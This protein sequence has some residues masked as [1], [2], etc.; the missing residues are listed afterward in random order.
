VSV[1]SNYPEFSLDDV[2]TGEPKE[3]TS[4]WKLCAGV[5]VVTIVLIV[6]FVSLPEDMQSIVGLGVQIVY[7]SV[8]VFILL[9]VFYSASRKKSVIAES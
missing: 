4:G 2:Y 1:R 5:M 3:K 8:T 7:G 9:Y 6:I